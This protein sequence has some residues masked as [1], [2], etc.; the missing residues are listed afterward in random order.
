MSCRKNVF[1]GF[2][3]VVNEVGC[4]VGGC[5]CEVDKVNYTRQKILKATC[6]ERKQRKSN[7]KITS[8]II[9]NNNNSA[10]GGGLGTQASNPSVQ[11]N[12]CLLCVFEI[13]HWRE[14][15]RRLVLSQQ[16]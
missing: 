13:K 5:Q 16:L 1:R 8:H 11:L 2:T 12:I 9:S 7:T 4:C 15:N 6:F 3:E 10:E 14:W